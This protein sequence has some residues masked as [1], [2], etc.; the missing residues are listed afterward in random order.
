MVSG[1]SIPAKV[2]SRTIA[3]ISFSGEP[4]EASTSLRIS[5]D[6]LGNR[7]AEMTLAD[8]A[9]VS[10]TPTCRIQT[11]FDGAMF[12][13]TEISGSAVRF[14]ADWR[15]GKEV[16]YRGGA[17][18][19]THHVWRLEEVD[20][21]R[22]YLAVDV[23]F[24]HDRVKLYAA[25][26]VGAK[27]SWMDG[28]SSQPPRQRSAYKVMARSGRF[29]QIGDGGWEGQDLKPVGWIMWRDADGG[30]AVWHAYYDDC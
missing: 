17:D 3:V 26:R 4:D 12:P 19:Y 21:K 13:V 2:L 30:L 27:F 14:V 16:W 10:R 1:S 18:V 20:P 5:R 7:T 9:P 25:P 11:G 22:G 23:F 8:A 15:T 28:G 6:R 29:L 24:R